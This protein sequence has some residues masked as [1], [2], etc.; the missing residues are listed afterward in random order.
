M[1]KIKLQVCVHTCTAVKLYD[2][3]TSRGTV[4]YSRPT[5]AMTKLQDT[6]TLWGFFGVIQKQTHTVRGS[7]PYSFF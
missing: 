7:I 3:P 4:Y 5:L 6:I 2:T 1:D